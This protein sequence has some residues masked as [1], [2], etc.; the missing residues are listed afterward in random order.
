MQYAYFEINASVRFE[1]IPPNGSFVESVAHPATSITLSIAFSSRWTRMSENPLLSV[2]FPAQSVPLKSS[3]VS[4]SYFIV[5]IILSRID[6]E[7]ICIPQ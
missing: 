6:I 7:V 2:G 3:K 1:V 4:V 5:Y